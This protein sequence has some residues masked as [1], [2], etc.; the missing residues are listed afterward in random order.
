MKNISR[1]RLKSSP[2]CFVS[3]EEK[4]GTCEWE[5]QDSEDKSKLI[6]ILIN[7]SPGSHKY[8]TSLNTCVIHGLNW[9]FKQMKKK[10]IFCAGGW[11]WGEG[12]QN[13]KFETKT[14]RVSPG[15]EGKV[16]N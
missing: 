5:V 16:R 15:R 12:S 14:L 1:R 9:G 4:V 10:N 6:G 2:R 8:I 3:I 7:I 11:G 13:A